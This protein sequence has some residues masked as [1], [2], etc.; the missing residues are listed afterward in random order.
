MTEDSYDVFLCY[1]SRD[2]AAVDSFARRLKD[3][4]FRVFYDDWEMIPGRPVQ[5]Q[6]EA[7]LEGSRTYAV[8]LGPKGLGPWQTEEMRVALSARVHDEPRRVIAVLMPGA[9]E[10]DLPAFLAR[11]GFV[12]FRA[13]LDDEDAFHRL[14]SA[15]RGVAPGSGPAPDISPPVSGHRRGSLPPTEPAETSDG[16]TEHVGKLLEIKRRRLRELEKKA[17]FKGVDAPVDVIMEMEDLRKEIDELAGVRMA[18]SG[19]EPAALRVSSMAERRRPNPFHAGFAVRDAACFVGRRVEVQRLRDLL[20][21]GCVTLL[22]EPKIGKSSLVLEL[23]RSWDG[24]VIGPIDFHGIED[25]DDF[26]DTLAAGLG[27]DASDWRTSVR[28]ELRRRRALLLLDELDAAPPDRLTAED[29]GR[30]RAVC[31]QNQNL[32]LVA[33]SR[34]PVKDLFPDAGR[35]S[36]VY[37]FLVH[38]DLGPLEDEDVRCLLM[39]WGENEPVFEGSVVE[40]IVRLVGG[41]PAKAQLAAHHRYESLF[42]SRHDWRTAWERDWQRLQ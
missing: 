19:A 27:L 8:I 29:L 11:L 39:P 41:H 1:N 2:K 16:E 35:G 33:V 31:Q 42:D 15:I 37:N 3:A 25:R 4:G 18:P 36:P 9:S 34:T 26:Y 20:A 6:L 10:E 22:G 24:D 40:E 14:Q 23:K 38:F 17:A 7:A 12:D 13:G 21:H 30:L 28:P 32:K 5:E